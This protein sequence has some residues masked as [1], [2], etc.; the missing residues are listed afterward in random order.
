MGR[1]TDFFTQEAQALTTVNR[2]LTRNIDLFKKEQARKEA[3]EKKKAEI[4]AREDE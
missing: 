3:L 2:L 1:K 4:K